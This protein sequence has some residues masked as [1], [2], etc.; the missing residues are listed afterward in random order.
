MSDSPQQTYTCDTLPAPQN[1][2]VRHPHTFPRSLMSR[3]PSPSSYAYSPQIDS[4]F[5]TA[6][7]VPTAEEVIATQ[8]SSSAFKLDSEVELS[9][10][11]PPA[12]KLCVRHQ[13]MADEGTIIKLQQVSCP[14]LTNSWQSAVIRSYASFNIFLECHSMH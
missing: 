1:I 10:P 6:F 12:R 14:R 5:S 9:P 11:Q 3:S 8:A 4:S 2:Q 7:D 13:R